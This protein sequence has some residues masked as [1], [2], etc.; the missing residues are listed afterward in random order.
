MALPIFLALGS[1][2]GLAAGIASR[3]LVRP[4][5]GVPVVILLP[6]VLSAIGP[7]NDSHD[8]LGEVESSVQIA[9]TPAEVWQQLNGATDITPAEVDAAWI[10]RIGVPRPV[11]GVTVTPAV[12]GVRLSRWEKN[13]HFRERITDWQEARYVRWTY[14]FDAHSFPPGA[15]DDHVMIGGRYFDLR[16]TSYRLE[17]SGGGTRLTL[18]TQYRVTTG[19]NWYS[20]AIADLVLHDFSDAILTM[21]RHRAEK[22][23]ASAHDME[24]S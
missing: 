5:A 1:I 24:R 4:A 3:V 12:G 9:A 13:V 16:S 7:G 15:L 18:R 11:A 21:Y 20:G 6:L 17:P 19:F 10:Y 8:R 2:G 14:E 22:S 23:A